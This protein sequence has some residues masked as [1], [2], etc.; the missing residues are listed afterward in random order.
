M[1]ASIVN[2][3]LDSHGRGRR[4]KSSPSVP[5]KAMREQD[6]NR[7]K[8]HPIFSSGHAPGVQWVTPFLT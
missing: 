8:E 1:T 5:C 3:T 6:V 2:G 4:F 7:E